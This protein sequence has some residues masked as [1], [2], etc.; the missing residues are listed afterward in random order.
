[1]ELD[2]IDDLLD[3]GEEIAEYLRELGLKANTRKVYHLHAKGRLPIGQLGR[4][5]IASR[6]QIRPKQTSSEYSWSTALK[7]LRFLSLAST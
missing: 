7:E 1:M 6:A 2:N 4:N 5:L 3:G